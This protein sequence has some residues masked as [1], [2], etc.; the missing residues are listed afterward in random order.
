MVWQ[1]EIE[2]R[3]RRVELALQMGGEANVARQHA[4]GKLRGRERI[5]R[6]R[7][8]DSFGEGGVLGGA[9]M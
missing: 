1:P 6:R 3:K 4:G 5:G 8:P 7:D 9:P 2:E